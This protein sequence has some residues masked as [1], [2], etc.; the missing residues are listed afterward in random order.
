MT[1]S[2]IE[3]GKKE[4]L[5]GLYYFNKGLF[6]DAENSYILSLKHVPSRVSTLNNLSLAQ[7]K[8]RKFADA[9]LNIEQVLAV[10][11][12]N[13]E[14]WF[15]LAIIEKE[16]GNYLIAED[17]CNCAINLQ[18]NF[19]EALIFIG[20]IHSR[21]NKTEA[22]LS[23]YSK[24][25]SIDPSNENAISHLIEQYL[26]D[27]KYTEALFYAKKYG[28]VIKKSQKLSELLGYL[29]LSN[30]D[31]EL[32]YEAFKQSHDLKEK[33]R[34]VNAETSKPISKSKIKHEYEQLSHIL[35]KNIESD[36]SVAA[37]AFLKQNV[38]SD[39]SSVDNQ[40]KQAI[41]EMLDNNHYIPDL[42]FSVKALGSNNY[43]QIESDYLNSKFK[44]VVID[45]FLT[46][47][48]LL[49]LRQFCEE[50]N[51]WKRSY[52]DGYLGAVLAEGFY[53]RV[54]LSIAD[55]LKISL[56]RVIGKN[57]LF[58]GWAFKYDQEMTGI[59]LHADFA[60]VNV[61]FWITPDEACIDKTSGGMIIYDTP[62]PN[63]WS[64]RDYNGNSKKLLEYL[65]THNSK[66]YKVPYK[67]N[68][69]V[70]FDSA[71]IHNTDELNFK[72]GYQN[73]RINCTLLF[74]K[75]LD[76]NV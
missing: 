6:I 44:L 10:E 47:A 27:H 41:Q 26:D 73:R 43:H 38:T 34:V 75:Q 5:D 22:A 70:L 16:L 21:N 17:H 18:P 11:P 48:A 49:N 28:E 56:P 64:F 62:V 9:K 40:K 55:E 42:Q 36:S 68:R 50:A 58:Q 25:L 30:G 67:M 7:I 54:F 72:S 8:L 33:L 39:I 1:I 74:G 51:V 60:K 53:S 52:D 29:Y 65:N 57:R 32:S 13:V 3:L 15:N 4:F 19:I 14:A 37:H 76:V 12:K 69:C 46:D 31:K 71:Y 66:P 23:T 45:N 59:N 61:N 35:S 2:N 20:E 63:Y 24:V